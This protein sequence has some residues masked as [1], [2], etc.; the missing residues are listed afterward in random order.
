MALTARRLS[1]QTKTTCVLPNKQQNGS[2]EIQVKK[3]FF[4]QI[5]CSILFNLFFNS[6]HIPVD[7]HRYVVVKVEPQNAI[8]SSISF[9]DSALYSSIIKSVQKY[10][11]DLGAA[12]VRFGL[13]CKYC[14]DQTRIAIVRVKHKIHRFVTSIL[15]M[16]SIVSV[17]LSS[18]A[19]F[20][21]ELK[22]FIYF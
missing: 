19:K 15:P 12:S 2:S 22:N 3:S 11:G 14:N 16:T 1:K 4:K 13:K 5:S 17:Y 7:A 18:R 9:S 6:I 21:N 20:S 8:S 10:Y